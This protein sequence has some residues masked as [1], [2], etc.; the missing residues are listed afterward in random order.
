MANFFTKLFSPSETKAADAPVETK[1]ASPPGFHGTTIYDSTSS[2]LDAKNKT[3]ETLVRLAFE[4]NVIGYRCVDMIARA[5]ST[6]DYYLVQGGK[7]DEIDSH[8][9]LSLLDTPNPTQSRE[10]FIAQFI[11]CKLLDGNAYVELLG[12][13]GEASSSSP[14]R[15]MWLLRPDWV[16]TDMAQSRIPIRY[17]YTP[18]GFGGGAPR[19]FPVSQLDGSCSL[20]HS[21]GF[22]PL[23]DTSDHRGFAPARAAFL[24]LMTHRAGAQWNHSLLENSARP[25]GAFLE[26]ATKEGEVGLTQEHVDDIR[27]Q[28]NELYASKSKAGRL[29]VIP[30]GLSFQELSL[31]PKDADYSNLKNS[32][33]S[34]IARTFGVPDQMLGI[35]GSLTYANMEQAKESFY[36][37]TVLPIARELCGDINRRVLPMFGEGLRLCVD[38]DSVVALAPKRKVKWDTVVN[39]P[40]LTINEK[41]KALGYDEIEGGDE[42][43]IPSGLL[44]LNANVDDS[45]VDPEV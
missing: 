6:L 40:I 28:V 29:M 36:E 23:F 3:F 1:S 10:S 12:P 16:R 17:V 33:S 38:E 32:M 42:L 15:E 27:K 13:R 26:K 44:P 20:L 37:E 41:R 18:G 25:S 24:S 11:G 9:F 21:K 19:T 8:P 30:G 31:S 5:V 2:S 43:L 7:D 14:P 39:A 45:E 4:G 34:D 22:T 35:P